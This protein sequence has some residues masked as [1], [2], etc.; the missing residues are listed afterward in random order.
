M[1]GLT[2]GEI[3]HML[4]KL[5]DIKNYKS[6]EIINI[7]PPFKDNPC[8]AQGRTPA[9]E[10]YKHYSFMKAYVDLYGVYEWRLL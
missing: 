10:V 7:L 5:P 6:G 2:Q 3:Q 9:Y 1:K 8:L 4:D